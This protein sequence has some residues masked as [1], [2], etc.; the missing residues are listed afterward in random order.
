[1]LKLIGLASLTLACSWL[2]WSPDAVLDARGEAPTPL[3]D[4]GA[5]IIGSMLAHAGTTYNA[6]LFGAPPL[7]WSWTISGAQ[8]AA[9]GSHATSP[10]LLAVPIPQ[11]AAGETLT[12]NLN[13]A[14]G[15]D[16]LQVPI[17]P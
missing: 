15:S 3:I 1:M 16:L 5:D 9:S 7:Q 2:A 17:V 6:N 10:M 11:G 12:I 14:N 13:A 8:G 4:R